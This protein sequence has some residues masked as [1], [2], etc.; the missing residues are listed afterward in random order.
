MQN[1]MVLDRETIQTP[2]GILG[3]VESFYCHPKGELSGVNLSEKNMIVTQAGELVPAYTETARRKKKPSVEFNKQGMIIS[4]YPHWR[5]SSRAGQV[6]S[7]RR[8][9]QSIYSRWTAKRLLDGRG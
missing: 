7:F 3:G 6:L 1:Y 4:V 8:T 9:S 5:A 2:Y